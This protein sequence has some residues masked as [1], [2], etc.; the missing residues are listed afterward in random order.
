[1]FHALTARVRREF[2]EAYRLFVATFRQA[3]GET[4][5]S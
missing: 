1:M 3:A 4:L 5:K 2:W